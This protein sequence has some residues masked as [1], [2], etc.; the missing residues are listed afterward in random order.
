[1]PS[2]RKN[3][4]QQRGAELV[5]FAVTLPIILLVAFILIEFAVALNNQAVLTDA[6]RAAA[7][8]AIKG[9]TEAAARAAARD[10]YNARVLWYQSST[11][12]PAVSFDPANIWTLTNSP[13]R[14]ITVTVTQ[15]LNLKLIP[16]FLSGGL[17]NLSLTGRT[18]MRE[19]KH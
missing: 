2:N 1:M 13:G 3:R 11:P 12:E 16:G 5:E 6:S 10:V 14:P 17:Q 7:L 15:N 8:Q 4:T 19:L 9:N 18:V